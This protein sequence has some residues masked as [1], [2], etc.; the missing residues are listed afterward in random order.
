MGDDRTEGSSAKGN[1]EQAAVSFT[2]DIDG[3]DCGFLLE[4]DAHL[5]L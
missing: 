1:G 5:H 2:P 3:A 4:P